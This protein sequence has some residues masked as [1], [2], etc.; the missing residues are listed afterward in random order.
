MRKYGFKDWES[1]LAAIGRGGLKEGQVINRLL[2]E[3]NKK[4]NTD[5]T[6]DEVLGI[7]SDYHTTKSSSKK[8]KSGIVVEGID[9][10]AVRF[11]KCCSPVPGDEI[12]GFVTRGRGVSIHRTDCVNVINLAEDDREIGRA[13][14]RER[15]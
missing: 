1:I 9:D 15:V 10:V 8:S 11:S 12:V 4:N 7:I 2:D 6:D 13:S 14:C 5:I 3:Y